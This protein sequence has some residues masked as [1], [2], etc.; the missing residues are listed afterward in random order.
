MAVA[1][2]VMRLSVLFSTLCWTSV[3]VNFVVY[4]Q[5]VSGD[6]KS[7]SDGSHM[8]DYEAPV[9]AVRVNYATLICF[10]VFAFLWMWSAE[11]Q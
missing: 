3:L 7:N 8:T 9:W 6:F 1:G 10:G 5:F 2:D 11:V 4:R